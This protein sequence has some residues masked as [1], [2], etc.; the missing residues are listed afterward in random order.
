M[1][2]ASCLALVSLALAADDFAGTWVL[3]KAKSDP[4]RGPAADANVTLIIKQ[5]ANEVQITR[6]TVLN[7]N[8]RSSDQKFTLDGKEATTPAP[9]GRGAITAKG[10]LVQNAILIGGTQACPD[11]GTSS[12]R[13]KSDRGQE[14]QAL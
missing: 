1:L 12:S 11:K 9:G 10:K 8:E 7:G 3:D 2:V 6:K 14:T 5:S 13:W 4:T